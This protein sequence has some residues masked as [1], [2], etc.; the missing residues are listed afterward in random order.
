MSVLDLKIMV[1]INGCKI[2][3]RAH[4]KTVNVISELML[5]T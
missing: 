1:Q 2:K 5:E 4:L 3:Y